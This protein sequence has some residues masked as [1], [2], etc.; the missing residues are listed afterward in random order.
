MFSGFLVVMVLLSF[1]LTDVWSIAGSLD[2]H[3]IAEFLTANL[4]LARGSS[5]PEVYGK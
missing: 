3:F 5:S 1:C 2:S 4:G